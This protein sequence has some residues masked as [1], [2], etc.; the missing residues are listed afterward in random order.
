MDDINNILI[1]DYDDSDMSSGQMDTIEEELLLQYD[2]TNYYNLEETVNGNNSVEE[3]NSKSL[4]L[5]L[6]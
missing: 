6:F 1:V 4:F 5:M 3:Q 2:E